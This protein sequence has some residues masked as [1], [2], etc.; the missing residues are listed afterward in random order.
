MND[1]W[2]PRR[3]VVTVCL[4]FGLA[5]A[6]PVAAARA[7]VVK[8]PYLMN[9]TTS[10]ITVCWVSDGPATGAVRYKLPGQATQ[11]WATATDAATL[12]KTRYH[13]VRITNLRPYT[14]YEYAVVD[15]GSAPKTPPL[16][17]FRT[18]APP[19][20]PFRFV[21]YGDTRTQPD[22]HAAVIARIAQFRP[23]F[24]LQTGDQVANGEREPEWD[25]FFATAEP[26]L[27]DAAY[28]P[29]LG[30]HEHNAAPYFK[31]FPVPRD[32]SFDYGNVH[33]VGL[34]S[35]RPDGEKT[36]QDAWLGRDLA[37]HQSA[38]WRVVFLHHTPYTC[39]DIAQR[40]L[41]SAR[42]RARLE[43]IFQAGRVQ[44]VITGHDHTYQR[45]VGPTGIQYVVSGGGGAPLYDIRRG[46][47]TSFTVAAK[48][49]YNDCE[50]TVNGPLLSLR[51]VEPD[52]T[53]IDRF[54]LSADGSVR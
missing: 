28:F 45:H 9:P 18:A 5:L 6:A 27:K 46:D 39:V 16:A 8:G 20:Q 29:E 30:N 47:D 54:D 43:P 53:Q 33:F 50:I 4:A 34:D 52:G 12:G 11:R 21:A 35:N 3:A 36:A 41:D 32:Y 26:M 13:R 37:V 42:L 40:R 25:V 14:R 7:E 24:V 23:D 19:G 2:F 15:N 51:A 44:L 22:K 48:K 1:F 17:T 10:A 49:A 38:T 31:Y